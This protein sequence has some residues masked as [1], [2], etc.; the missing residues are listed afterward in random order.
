ME[1]VLRDGL[2]PCGVCRTRRC[3]V[4]TAGGVSADASGTSASTYDWGSAPEAHTSRGITVRAD[5][6][7]AGLRLRTD[8]R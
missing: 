4:G 8:F 6:P 5:W 7:S 2:T 3:R 1:V